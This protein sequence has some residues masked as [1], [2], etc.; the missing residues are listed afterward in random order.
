M[1]HRNAWLGIGLALALCFTFV[2]G[3]LQ[4]A[5]DCPDNFIIVV[6]QSGS[7]YM[8]FAKYPQFSAQPLTKMGASKKVALDLNALIPPSNQ[9]GMDWVAAL[10]LVAPV[11]ELYAPALYDRAR[12]DKALK[13]IKDEQPIFDRTTP[14][15]PG[16]LSLD[17]VLARM[18]GNT[19]VILISDGMAN[20]GSDPVGEA[21]ALYSKYPNICLHIISMAD[22]QDKEGKRIL[23]EISRLSTCSI[24]VEGLTLYS[25]RAALEKFVNVAFCAPKPPEIIKLRGIH[26]DFNKAVIKPESRVVLDEAVEILKK[27]PNVRVLIEGHCDSIGTNAYNQKLSERRA[28]AV[29]DY[30]VKQGIGSVRLDTIGYGEDRPEVSNTKPDGSDDPEGRARNRRVELKPL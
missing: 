24:M 5:Q 18:R 1:K 6:D 22:T 4:A 8:H 30:F 27:R 13:S 28:K 21:K 11:K 19:A 25:D 20:E 12:M 3:P 23:T 14:L 9:K 2:S 16:L 26:F 7:M 17:P 15:G 10:E 29:Y